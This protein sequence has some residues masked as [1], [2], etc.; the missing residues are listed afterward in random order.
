MS[1]DQLVGRELALLEIEVGSRAR[2]ARGAAPAGRSACRLSWRAEARSS[3]QVVSTPSSITARR[4]VGR[5]SPSNGRL[6]SPRLRCGIVDDAD[7]VGEDLLAHLV[8]EEGGAARH[9]AAVDGAG[10]M[11]EQPARDARGRRSPARGAFATFF[12]LSRATAKRAGVAADLGGGHQV[13]RNGRRST[14][15]SRA[16]CRCLRRPAP[17]QDSE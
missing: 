1:A 10:E 12:G 15:R 13:A 6:P 16:P 11:A 4:L 8:L 2:A 3:S 7:A 14:I 9:G 17:T 5:P